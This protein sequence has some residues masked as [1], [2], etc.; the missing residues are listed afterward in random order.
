MSED[1]PTNSYYFEWGGPIHHGALEHEL[2]ALD[3]VIGLASWHGLYT[4]QTDPVTGKVGGAGKLTIVTN[5]DTPPPD[6]DRVYD[7]LK[8]HDP[9]FL[10]LESNKIEVG[11][12]TKLDIYAPRLDAA[13]VNVRIA[14]S[15]FNVTLVKGRAVL[16]IRG[17]DPVD[18]EIRLMAGANRNND[19]LTLRIV[20]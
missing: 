1:N 5:P 6:E 7:I 18:V 9:V 15:T 4:P 10:T 14:D 20:E 13:A 12:L 8:T 16:L 2:K 11:D 19:V 17:D 3:G